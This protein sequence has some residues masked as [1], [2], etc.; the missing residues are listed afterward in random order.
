MFIYHL[1]LGLPHSPFRPHFLTKHSMYSYFQPY[2][3]MHLAPPTKSSLF[4]LFLFLLY[5]A[6]GTGYETVLHAVFWGLVLLQHFW[7][8]YFTEHPVLK[9]SV[10]F[11]KVG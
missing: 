8:K 1:R 2:M 11:F 3:S 9:H 4:L 6:K 7:S 5:V 10:S